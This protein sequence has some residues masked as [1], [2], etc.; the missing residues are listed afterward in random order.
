MFD[1]WIIYFL[2]A[3]IMYLIWLYSQKARQIPE[4][5]RCEVFDEYTK[6]RIP[7]MPL[8]L[9]SKAAQVRTPLFTSGLPFGPKYEK[10]KHIYLEDGYIVFHWIPYQI[11]IE[12]ENGD[13]YSMSFYRDGFDRERKGWNDFTEYYINFQ[14][15]ARMHYKEYVPQ[16]QYPIKDKN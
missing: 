11:T 13:T 6:F 14:T 3:L 7:A 5:I 9:S 4:L 15:R 16:Y 1:E 12:C 10:N 2:S 8:R